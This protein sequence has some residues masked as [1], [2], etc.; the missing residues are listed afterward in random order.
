M[1]LVFWTKR[2]AKLSQYHNAG[3]HVHL[4]RRDAECQQTRGPRHHIP[5]DM[6]VEQRCEKGETCFAQKSA[7]Y[8]EVHANVQKWHPLHN[9]TWFRLDPASP[10]AQ[11]TA[12]RRRGE[13]DAPV[14]VI[15]RLASLQQTQWQTGGRRLVL[16][17]ICVSL[18]IVDSDA[19]VCLLIGVAGVP[20]DKLEV[21]EPFRVLT[22]RHEISLKVAH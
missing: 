16:R 17:A 18:M 21:L 20:V 8:D 4:Y 3:K 12:G 15:V 13:W 11:Q 2:F 1:A 14:S 19:V 5:A 10:V 9:P 22:T 6:K 7:G